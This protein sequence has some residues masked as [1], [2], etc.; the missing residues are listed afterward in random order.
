[1]AC[2]HCL[3]S[4]CLF[5]R[6]T[7]NT[8]QALS[9]L[10]LLILL[11]RLRFLL[12]CKWWHCPPQADPN[13]PALSNLSYSSPL[14]PMRSAMSSVPCSFRSGIAGSGCAY[15]IA[16]RFEEAQLRDQVAV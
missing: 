14:T 4:S 13:A 10:S 5:C 7:S 2:A 8:A 1:M 3:Y 9:R 16:D 12:G 15:P 6:G 11:L